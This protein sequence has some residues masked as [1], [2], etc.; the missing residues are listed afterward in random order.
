VRIV[1][2]EWRFS[3]AQ[4]SSIAARNLYLDSARFTWTGQRRRRPA[5]SATLFSCPNS[6]HISGQ[7]IGQPDATEQALCRAK[8]ELLGDGAIT[9][10]LTVETALIRQAADV[11]DD[12]SMVLGPGRAGGPARCPLVDNSL[13]NS[14]LGREVVSAAN[15]R[16]L[17]ATEAAGQLACLI[18]E[19]ARKLRSTATAFEA[20]EISRIGPPR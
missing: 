11:L 20:A 15:R 9:V 1:G 4:L 3:A 7:P 12:A 13:G 2:A 10:D 19:T 18:G 5:Q 16:V 14:A 17:Q 8:S 6:V